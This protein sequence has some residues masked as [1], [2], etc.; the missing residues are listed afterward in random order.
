[1]NGKKVSERSLIEEVVLEQVYQLA[2]VKAPEHS[3]ESVYAGYPLAAQP[4][5]AAIIFYAIWP[6]L[7]I[8]AWWLSRH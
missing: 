1:M 5:F 2:G 6:L 7:T 4:K 3:D 8:L